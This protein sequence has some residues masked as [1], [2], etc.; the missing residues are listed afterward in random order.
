[1]RKLLLLLA[2]MMVCAWTA[3][4]QNATYRG[5]V[6]D[7]A[8]GEPLIGATVMPI[9]GGQGVATDFD[10][11]FTITLPDNINKA[12][13]SYIGFAEH[14]ASLADGM[15]VR[16]HSE[17][18]ALDDVVV[19]AYG[20]ANKESLTGSVAVVG[21]K[22][23]GER[24][25]SSVTA[26]LEGN[27]PGVQVNNST[28][29]PGESPSIRIRG[30]NSING[31]NGPLY[32][33]DG[34]IYSGDIS[35]LNPQDIESMSVLKDAAS[36]AL[37]GS[38]GANGVILIT[39]KKARSIGK[40]DVTLQVGQGWNE[41]ALPFYDRL[42]ANE[43]METG[44]KALDNGLAYDNAVDNPFDYAGQTFI[45]QVAQLNIY[46]AAPEDVF[47]AQGR[48]A[49]PMIAGYAGDRDWWKAVSQT[50]R[51]EEHRVKGEVE[52]TMAMQE[53]YQTGK[54]LDA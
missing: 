5:T 24:P 22:D 33:V 45:S 2:A 36:C 14:T 27:A 30:F 37:Y 23:I 54:T 16:L 1:M 32:V 4:A 29:I 40:V 11:R 25:I 46:D 50:G 48:I 18:T 43:W 15:T 3:S 6:L 38:R 51:S 53:A 26:A 39:T 49:A 10:G 17:D 13:F 34:T 7:A 21:A 42:G 9:G 41:R 20:T 12:R 19:V 31:S 28:S 8:T 44:L 52:S 47:D 35:A